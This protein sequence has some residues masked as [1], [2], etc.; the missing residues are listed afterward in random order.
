M[1]KPVGISCF[2]YVL[3]FNLVIVKH[4][5]LFQFILFLKKPANQRRR[6]IEKKYKNFSLPWITST[7]LNSPEVP[8]L[9]TVLRSSYNPSILRDANRLICFGNKEA[10]F[11][12]HRI[13]N[14]RCLNNH[15]IPN[16]LRVKPLDRGVAA[17]KIVEGASRNFLTETN[18][19]EAPQ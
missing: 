7:M 19:R 17:R 11:T 5:K 10:R 6:N 8:N 2:V 18:W 16:S 13:F 9:F 4:T 12:N 3:I 14:L 15:V 1:A